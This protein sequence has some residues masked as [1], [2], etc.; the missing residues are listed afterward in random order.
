[1]TIKAVYEKGMFRPTEA[2]TLPEGTVVD[3]SVR[4]FA[5]ADATSVAEAFARIATLPPEPGAEQSSN[6]DH[7]RALYGGDRPR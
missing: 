1:M 4:E 6:R 3:V 5:G 2:V 7:D